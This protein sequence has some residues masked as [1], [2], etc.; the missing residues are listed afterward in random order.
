MG[1]VANAVAAFN[2]YMDTELAEKPDAHWRVS[3]AKKPTKAKPNGE[4]ADW[5]KE[6]APVWLDAYYKWRLSNMHY[7]PWITPEGVPAIELALM[8]S[9][10]GTDR[11]YRGYLDRLFVDTRDE[12]LLIVDLKTG[13][14]PQASS[15][16]L[17]SYAF[18]LRQQFGIDVRFGSY[19]DAR[20]GGLDAVY[21]LAQ[22]PD[23]LI[24]RWLRNMDRAVQLNDYTPH[25]SKECGWCD[26][27]EHCFVW[28]PD[29]ERPDP[30]TDLEG[31]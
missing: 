7:Q 26:V 9:I 13:K 21:D 10:P 24:A 27:R 22:F 1:H 19:Y 20:N 12:S 5:F 18:A 17:A 16:Q 30:N 8:V 3:G 31:K 4:D 11:R 28:N 15:L 23:D 2:E 29:V 25:I 6:Q 14:T